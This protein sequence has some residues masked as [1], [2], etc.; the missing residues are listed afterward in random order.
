[1]SPARRSSGPL[2]LLKAGTTVPGVRARRGD[3]EDWFMAGLVF[4]PE[5]VAVIDLAAGDPLPDPAGA[6]GAVVTGSSAMVTDEHPWS[7]RARDWLPRAVEAGIPLLGICYGHQ[8]LAQALGGVGGW[9]PAGREIGTFEVELLPAAR[10][11]PLLAGLENPLLVQACHSQSVLELPP[12]AAHLCRNAHT[13]YQGFSLGERA[14]G[15]QFHP[16]F[17]ADVVRGYLL[18]R[19]EDCEAEGIDVD[20]RMAEAR[21]DEAAGRI[22]ERFGRFVRERAGE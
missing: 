9:S 17:D 5:E 7:L 22:L 13:P 12:G 11:D 8:L 18:D 15:F 20:R 1:M 6:C 14:W 21:D 4:A 3:F 10:R 19:R 16:E 2:L